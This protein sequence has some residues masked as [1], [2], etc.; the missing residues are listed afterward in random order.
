MAINHPT[1]NS[2]LGMAWKA[3]SPSWNAGFL[4]TYPIT[5]FLGVLCSV[6]S[7][8]YFWWRQKYSWEIL[9]IMVIIIIPTAIFGARFWFVLWNGGWGNFWIFS[10][11]SI[12]GGVFISTFCVSIYGY[13]KR[14][15]I[16]YR[17][18]FSIVLPNVILGQVIGRWGN[19]DNH[20]VFGAPVDSSALD[21]MGAMKSHMLI[22]GDDGAHYRQPLFFYEFIANGIG[23]IVMVLILLRK[24]WLKPGVVGACYLIWYGIV[25]LIMEPLRDPRDIMGNGTFRISIFVA[26]MSIAFGVIFFAYF[27]FF[28]VRL[29]QF[30]LRKYV[31]NDRN[32]FLKVMTI[33]F[34]AKNFEVIKP[35]KPR[36]LFGIIGYEKNDINSKKIFFG[37]KG[38]RFGQKIDFKKQFVLFGKVIENRQIIWLPIISDEAWTKGD[39]KRKKRSPSNVLKMHE[40]QMKIATE[41][42]RNIKQK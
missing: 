32:K 40:E 25:R 6:L 41:S 33:I 35:L 3:E 31:A 19:F 20:E 34:N 28:D 1:V 29:R 37:P 39:L 27:Q 22:A 17:T 42:R 9:Q 18:A 36:R 24:N 30:F 38:N 5:M 8:A 4:H 26:A 2:P 23:Y 21:W 16:D 10:G 12:H 15:Q 7:I 11:L 14:Q 13:T